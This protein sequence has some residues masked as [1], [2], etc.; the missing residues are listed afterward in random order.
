MNETPPP[1]KYLLR[2]IVCGNDVGAYEYESLAECERAKQ[3]Q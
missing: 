1:G 3:A 2:V